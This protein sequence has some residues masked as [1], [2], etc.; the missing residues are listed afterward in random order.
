MSVMRSQ[1]SETSQ[2]RI[3]LIFL[4]S[5]LQVCTAEDVD[6]LHSRNIANVNGNWNEFPKNYDGL[7]LPDSDENVVPRIDHIVQ[8]KAPKQKSQL[9]SPENEDEDEDDDKGGKDK[10]EFSE[11]H[12]TVNVRTYND[13]LLTILPYVIID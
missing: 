11:W 4:L 5:I 3:K 8:D 7:I 9:C 12:E 6:R 2:N 10:K 1:K 13:D